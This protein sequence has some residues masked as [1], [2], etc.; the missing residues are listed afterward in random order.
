MG[1]VLTAI[2]RSEAPS[3]LNPA[4]VFTKGW[5]LKFTGRAELYNQTAEQI[6]LPTF[7]RPGTLPF[8]AH[9]SEPV[10]GGFG[11]PPPQLV[12]SSADPAGTSASPAALP[13][14]G[15]PV[16]LAGDAER[17]A[18]VEPTPDEPMISDTPSD[19]Q[20]AFLVPTAEQ[21]TIHIQIVWPHLLAP[22]KGPPLPAIICSAGMR[23]LGWCN[24]NW[25]VL[26]VIANWVRAR[27]AAKLAAGRWVPMPHC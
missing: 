2:K 9:V 18:R 16:V 10:G 17:P 6:I 27:S 26:V 4:R 14:A 7:L 15:D 8:F 24:F 5:R 13:F 21:E 19:Y 22:N 23:T 12:A 11:R 20:P 3:V 1:D 25:K